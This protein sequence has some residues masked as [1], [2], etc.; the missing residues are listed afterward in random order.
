MKW[1]IQ[2]LEDSG[3]LIKGVLKRSYLKWEQAVATT[4]NY[5]EQTVTAR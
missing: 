1:N 3:L 2:S 4:S 5:Q